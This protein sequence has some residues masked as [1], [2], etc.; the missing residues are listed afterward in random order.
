MHLSKK[1]NTWMN[2]YHRSLSCILLLVIAMGT[3]SAYDNA[4]FYRATNFFYEPRIERE[5]LTTFDVIINTG[6]T[7]KGLNR[8]HDCV[9]LLDI[10]GVANM[11]ELGIGVDKDLS[12]V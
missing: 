12:N 1:R 6:S 9:P 7:Q 4:H 5:Y 8:C 2:R 10:Y 11:H 3:L